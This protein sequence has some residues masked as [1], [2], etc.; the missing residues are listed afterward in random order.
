MRLPR[1]GHF[2]NTLRVVPSKK[3]RLFHSV[4][5]S[6]LLVWGGWVTISRGGAAIAVFMLEVVLTI[7]HECC[8]CQH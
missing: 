2:T 8:S 6:G 7:S 3:K 1:I 4:A 5:P